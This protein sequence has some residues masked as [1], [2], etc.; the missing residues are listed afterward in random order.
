MPNLKT[1]SKISPIYNSYNFLIT[2]VHYM[3]KN[4]RNATHK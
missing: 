4:I 3:C 2:G 1:L